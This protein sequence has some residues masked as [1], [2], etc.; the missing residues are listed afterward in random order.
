[1]NDEEDKLEIAILRILREAPHPLGG[2]VIADKIQAYGLD[3]SGRTV[4]LHLQKMEQSG[5]VS[6]AQ[7]GR[8]GGRTITRLGLEEIQS[9]RVRDRVGYTAARVDA[10]AWQMDFKLAEQAGQIVLNVTTLDAAHLYRAIEEMTPVFAAGLGVGQYVALA[11]G[12][13]TLGGSPIPPGRIGIGT[14]CG[15]T[16]NGVL[17]GAGIPV[18]S[19]FGAVLEIENGRPL[20]FT[21]VIH[22]EGSSLDPLEI[23]I[24]AGLTNVRGAARSGH[25]RIGVSFREVPTVALG[26][27]ERIR[28]DLARIG[29]DGVLMIG[30][31]NQSLLGFPVSQG[32]TGIIVN[33]GLNPTAAIKES[34]VTT[35]NHALTALYE[36]NKLMHYRR[37]R[38]ELPES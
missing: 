32:N 3:V 38:E 26:E 5:L 16:V 36:Y 29:L 7:R 8:S 30:K 21:E 4:R 22:Y 37:L 1:L 35:E 11:R 27:V 15:V 31:P 25:G 9:A 6:H 2:D 19:R 34:G 12:G 24:Q 23:F 17:L 13:Q 33:G 10:M 28:A 14:V 18:V 20:R